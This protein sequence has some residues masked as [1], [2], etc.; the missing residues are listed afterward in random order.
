MLLEAAKD[1]TGTFASSKANLMVRN[2]GGTWMGRG[3]SSE[4]RS[5]RALGVMG[6]VVCR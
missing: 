3:G 5:G 4:A 1:Q 2:C 6:R